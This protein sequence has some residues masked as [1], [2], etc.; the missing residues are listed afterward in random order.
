M[1]MRLAG[2]ISL[3]SLVACVAPGEQ[4]GQRTGA[5]AIHPGAG[6]L[7]AGEPVAGDQQA[8]AKWWPIRLADENQCIVEGY[9]QG[10]DAFAQCVRMMIDQQSRPHRP[11]YWRSLD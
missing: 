4:A 8:V 3:L 10:T 7:A 11:I 6:L 5:A 2:I 1:L 9:Q